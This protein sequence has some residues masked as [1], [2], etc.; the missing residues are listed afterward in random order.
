M[1]SIS[2]DVPPESRRMIAAADWAPLLLLLLA[3]LAPGTVWT[4][5][6]DHS[7]NTAGDAMAGES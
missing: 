6:L 7:H 3:L 2:W 4:Q 5:T 1:A